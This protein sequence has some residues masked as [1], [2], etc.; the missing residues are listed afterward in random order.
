MDF[1]IKLISAFKSNITI[2]KFS[3]NFQK[4]DSIDDSIS[5]QSKSIKNGIMNLKILKIIIVIGC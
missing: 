1:L 2:K 3:T 4:Y 5:N